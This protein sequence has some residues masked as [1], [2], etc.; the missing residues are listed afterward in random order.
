MSFP[1][2]TLNTMVNVANLAHAENCPSSQ[3]PENCHLKNRFVI[4]AQ[5]NPFKPGITNN[6]HPKDLRMQQTAKHGN[7]LPHKLYNYREDTAIF[8]L[9]NR[10]QQ[11]RVPRK[12]AVAKVKF[13]LKMS[14]PHHSDYIF[15]KNKIKNK[16]FNTT[17]PNP[18]H[19]P[20]KP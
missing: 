11:K 5:Q 8:A 15:K 14:P 10:L 3:Y 6:I 16:T 17:A 13:H 2:K 19:R 9:L 12:V 4:F 7:K 1:C 18:Q 20:P